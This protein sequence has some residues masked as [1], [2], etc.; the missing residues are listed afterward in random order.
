MTKLKN[1]NQNKQQTQHD[2]NYVYIL[3]CDNNSYYT[4]YTT[5]I[6]RRYKEHVKG[7]SKCKFTRAFKPLKIM[8]CWKV[9]GDKNIAM[10]VEKYI[11]SLNKKGKQYLIDFPYKLSE[12][13]KNS[14]SLYYF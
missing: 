4:G 6:I 3:L 2:Y 10:K 11:K 1:L 14:Q 5:N 13:Y 7:T 8:R 12:L 9:Y